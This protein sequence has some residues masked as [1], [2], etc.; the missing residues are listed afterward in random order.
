MANFVSPGV[1]V[2][3]KDLSDYPV[4]INPSVVG[5]VGF[6][7][8]GPVDK[9][10]L[11]TS[12]ESLLQIFGR[13]SESIYGQGLE[14]SLE[15]LEATNSL[16]FVR[17][18]GTGSSEA[19]AAVA[20]GS[21]PGVHVSAMELGTTSGAV[22][23]VQVYNQYGVTQF[24]S[25]KTYTVPASI[26]DASS[27]GRALIHA[28]GSLFDG[29]KV[30]ATFD[31]ADTSTGFIV[32]GF[33]GSAAQISVSAY[34]T[35]GITPLAVLKKVGIT[36]EPEGAYASTITVRGTN[37]K[38][39]GASSIA[40]LAESLW[41][42]AG[43][44]R[45]IK[46]DG[47]YSGVAITV[48]STG[49]ESVVLGI[50]DEGALA[51]NFKVSLV[52]NKGFIE[53]TINT[54]VVDNTSDIIKGNL[55]IEGTDFDAS[56]LT[57]FAKKLSG[58][59]LTSNIIGAG[60]GVAAYTISWDGSFGGGPAPGNSDGVSYTLATPRFVKPLPG[61][62]AMKSGDSGIPT[63]DVDVADAIIGDGAAEPKTGM[64]ALDD[65]LLNISMAA[66]PGI[67]IPSVQN[68]LIT[69]A[70]VTKNFLA[71]V[72]PPYAVGSTQDAIDWTNGLAGDRT[73]AINSSYAA[74]YWPWVKT[75]S[76]F[77]GADRWYDPSIF[78]VRQMAFTDEV[79]D[80]WFAPAGFV[81][82]RLTKPTDVEVRLNQGD[83]DAMY[84]G[85]NVVNPIVNFPQQG[86]TIFGQRTTQRAPTALDR[87]NVR[88]MM[89]VI[90]KIL[91]AST[92]QFAFEPNDNVTWEKVTNVVE[93]LVDDIRRRR[94]ITE[95]KVICDET[96]NTPVR[97]DR[98]ELWCKVLI[99]PTKAA[100]IIVFEL[101]LTNQSA[102]IT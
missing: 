83:R 36:G 97:V 9:A 63:T 80:P 56:P 41:P 82:G 86:I 79:A 81:R 68:A 49:S 61:T 30:V 64:Q 87:V 32:G 76:Q 57:H 16:Y 89:I 12:Q 29:A 100:E 60:P 20:L 66:V 19:S 73:S 4:S 52:A 88:R 71:V 59:G 15:M 70:E 67:T 90:R 28:F 37:L 6:A 77:D 22:F 31:P 13:P 3:E 44:N 38:S 62:Y 33:A 35:D 58:L 85:G 96:T 11:I 1:Y 69:L 5:V 95:F 27:Q 101:N 18:A 54:G 2:I 24:G 7:D 39:E 43:Y 102:N 23:K 46:S 34:Q 84:S 26:T 99:K 10:T 50:E 53:D 55:V 94:G 45:G 21:C 51:E 98:N 74:V 93:P 40:Y 25:P 65:D 17:A 75:F 72:S 8:R 92:R 42:G 48:N 14:G 78:A 91:L 47:T